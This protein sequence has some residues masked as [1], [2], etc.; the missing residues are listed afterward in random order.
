MSGSRGLGLALAAAILVAGCGTATLDASALEDEIA[1]ELERQSAE[2]PA[3]DCP[4]DE[5]ATAETTFVCTL[6]LSDDSR[7]AVRVTLLD[8][9]GAFRFDLLPP[10]R[11]D[12]AVGAEAAG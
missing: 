7:S 2:R 12:E 4:D 5:E 6:T 3:V 11:V 8:D 10:G 1:A 9:D